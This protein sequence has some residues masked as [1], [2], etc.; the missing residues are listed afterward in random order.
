MSTCKKCAYKHCFQQNAVSL[1]SNH[2]AYFYT[3]ILLW[4]K[5]IG[6]SIK[7]RPVLVELIGAKLMI[8]PRMLF[9]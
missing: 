8:S 7:V 9:E 4:N 1:N 5:T 3:A 2:L 6:M